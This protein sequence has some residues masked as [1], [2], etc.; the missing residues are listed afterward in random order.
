M[1]VALFFQKN[2]KATLKEKHNSQNLGQLVHQDSLIWGLRPSMAFRV[3]VNYLKWFAEQ[4]VMHF[5]QE[6]SLDVL[7]VWGSPT[8]SKIYYYKT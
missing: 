1:H 6:E 2:S 8:K 5:S 4:M 7:G 3:L